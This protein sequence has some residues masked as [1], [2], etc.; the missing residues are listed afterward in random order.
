MVILNT[1]FALPVVMKRVFLDWLQSEYA[2]K[3]MASG[4]FSEAMTARVLGGDGT[5]N[6]SIAFQLKA[7]TLPQAK[8]WENDEGSHMLGAMM[9]KF[10][11]RIHFFTTY[12]EVIS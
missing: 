12:L 7:D 1:T 2:P 9:A 10:A 6:L 5:D 8:R 3:A 11:N 4:V